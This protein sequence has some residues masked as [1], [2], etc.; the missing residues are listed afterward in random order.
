[1]LDAAGA[2]LL[3]LYRLLTQGVPEVENIWGAQKNMC[4][5]MEAAPAE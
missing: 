2:R 4:E 5:T 1:M 3:A